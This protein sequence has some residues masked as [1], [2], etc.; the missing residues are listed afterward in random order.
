[1]GASRRKAAA[2]T[3]VAEYVRMS[4][5]SASV[6]AIGASML[7]PAE[8]FSATERAVS[9]EPKRGVLTVE[10]RLAGT[11]ADHAP[12]PSPELFTALTCTSNSSTPAVRLA[13]VYTSGPE[14]HPLSATV[15]FASDLSNASERIWRTS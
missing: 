8:V 10:S 2:S 6:A 1:M 5:W 11:V 9:D 4:P 7:T 3:P 14:V 12:S 15:Q 13:I